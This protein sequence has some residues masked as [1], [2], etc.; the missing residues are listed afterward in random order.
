MFTILFC[1]GVTNIALETGHSYSQKS[2]KKCTINK[3]LHV[4]Y[5]EEKDVRVLKGA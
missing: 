3:N 5:G 1:D 2:Q 4:E